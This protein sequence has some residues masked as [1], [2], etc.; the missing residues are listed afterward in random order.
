MIRPLLLT[1]FRP[2]SGGGEW[3]HRLGFSGEIVLLGVFMLLYRHPL[4]LLSFEV[5]LALGRCRRRRLLFT[6]VES[7]VAVAVID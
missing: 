1:Y 4:R 5:T 2:D 7:G 3:H 6:A